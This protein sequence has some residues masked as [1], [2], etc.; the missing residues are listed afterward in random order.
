MKIAE[1]IDIL[2]SPLD[3]VTIEKELEALIDKNSEPDIFDE[4]IDYAQTVLGVG[5]FADRNPSWWQT[6]HGQPVELGSKE[7]RDGISNLLRLTSKHEV[8][9]LDNRRNHLKVSIKLEVLA[10]NA[11]QLPE[12]VFNGAK[13]VSVQTMF[14][15]F[16]IVEG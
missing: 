12:T 4:C 3:V 9:D 15:V 1:K 5:E 10:I 11:K 14:G 8:S 7:W 13:C 16:P 6:F 2:F